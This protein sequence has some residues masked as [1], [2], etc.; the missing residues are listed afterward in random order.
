MAT[1][2]NNCFLPTNTNSKIHIDKYTYW[3]E[4]PITVLET[5][6]I[7]HNWSSTNMGDRPMRRSVGQDRRAIFEQ[8]T[9][10]SDEDSSNTTGKWLITHLKI[11]SNRLPWVSYA[12]TDTLQASGRVL[13]CCLA[14]QVL[15]LV[16]TI[17][18]N[19]E[20]DQDEIFRLRPAKSYTWVEAHLQS[21]ITT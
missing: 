2:N 3:L 20:Y 19:R 6:S 16:M 7:V 8:L 18:V 14:D 21:G 1:I 13:L 11:R 15:Y 17:Y 9:T 12:N 10:S 4:K 5:H